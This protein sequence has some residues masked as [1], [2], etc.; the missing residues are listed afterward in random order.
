[1]AA[2]I[3]EV[4]CAAQKLQRFRRKWD[5]CYDPYSVIKIISGINGPRTESC[6][7]PQV[8]PNNPEETLPIET[9]C[10]LLHT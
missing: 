10:F 7:T 1:M 5:F 8:T 4:I 3:P 9:N 2:K 6:G